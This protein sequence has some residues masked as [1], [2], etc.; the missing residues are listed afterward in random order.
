MFWNAHQLCWTK[1]PSQ[2]A[3]SH[4]PHSLLLP[5]TPNSQTRLVV[6]YTIC[7]GP[8]HLCGGKGRD[9]SKREWGEQ[10]RSKREWGEQE[11][12]EEARGAREEWEGARQGG[13]H[14]L[15][16]GK[17]QDGRKREWGE[18]ERSEREW[19][20]VRGARGAREEWEGV[21]GA[22]GSK[23]ERGEWEECYTRF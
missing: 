15:C 8:H 11:E 23:R 3:P 10:E 1:G 12:Q 14:H 5:L 2:L 18:W 20:G 17:G 19:E 13:P 6:Y 4:S 9:G 22:R 7:R 21:R 16:G